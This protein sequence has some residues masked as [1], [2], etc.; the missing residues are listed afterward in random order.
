MSFIA[1]L[2]KSKAH[3]SKLGSIYEDIYVILPNHDFTEPVTEAVLKG[4]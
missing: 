3:W 2:H 1:P 4:F